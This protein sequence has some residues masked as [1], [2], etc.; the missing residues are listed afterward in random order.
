MTKLVFSKTLADVNF[1]KA[2]GQV[3]SLIIYD[4]VLLKNPKVARWIRSQPLKYE[5][6]AGEALKELSQFPKH[7]L[8][9]SK[10]V[11]ALAPK[12]LQIMALGGGSVGDFA[13][14]VASVYKRGVPLIQ[15]PSTW[16]AA[17]DSAHGGKNALNVGSVKNQLGTFHFPKAVVLVSDLLQ[18]QPEARAQEAFGEFFKMALIDLDLWK[19][20]LKMKDFSSQSLWEIL[21][22]LIQAKYRVVRKDPLEQ[23]G[24]RQILNL[25]HTVGHVLETLFGLPHGVAINYG[26]S[27]ALKWS[28]QEGFLSEKS[29]W[30]I[31]KH[32]LAARLLSPEVLLPQTTLEKKNFKE[33]LGVDKKR[34]D[35][36]TVNFIFIERPGKTLRKSV[37]FEDLMAEIQRQRL[38]RV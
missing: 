36:K 27:F 2:F 14:F 12:Q 33:L 37:D 16:L 25:G 24:H 10:L 15:C 26:L 17:M 3:E 7:M 1:E 35:P 13:G 34:N 4:Q 31:L 22:T 8:A 23:K 18:A 6:Q 30:K 20:S 32:P 29:L 38:N 28:V 9:I 19:K 11:S 21:P 5:V